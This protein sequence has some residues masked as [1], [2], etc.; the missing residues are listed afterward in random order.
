MLNMI[1]GKSLYNEGMKVLIYSEKRQEWV[2]EKKESGSASKKD[3]ELQEGWTRGGED[4][5]YFQN[6]YKKDQSQQ[7]NFQRCY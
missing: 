5:S 2:K 7:T 6:N 4:L 3:K 1:K